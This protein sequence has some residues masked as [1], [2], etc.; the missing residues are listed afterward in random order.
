VAVEQEGAVLV[1]V[2]QAG[3]EQG[4]GEEEVGEEAVGEEAAYNLRLRFHS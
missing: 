1:A 3:A 2:E 4:V